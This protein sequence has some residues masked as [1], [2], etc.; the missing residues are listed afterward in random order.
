MTLR[1]RNDRRREKKMRIESGKNNIIKTGESGRKAPSRK[2]HPAAKSAGA[3]DRP[4]R[5]GNPP[6]RLVPPP[7]TKSFGLPPSKHTTH[8]TREPPTRSTLAW[9]ADAIGHDTTPQT[10][11]GTIINKIT[12]KHHSRPGVDWTTTT[13]RVQYVSTRLAVWS[14]A[15]SI[16]PPLPAPHRVLPVPA[17]PP[18]TC[19]PAI[20]TRPPS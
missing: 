12:S 11:P 6:A 18:P 5:S 19:P 2:R 8:K 20:Q 9:A 7:S 17:P 16:P 15:C 13:V 4:S 1:S 14:S 10:G 3:Q